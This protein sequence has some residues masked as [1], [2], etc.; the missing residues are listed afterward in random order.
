MQPI[1]PKLS[2]YITLYPCEVLCQ[3]FQLTVSCDLMH[4][5]YMLYVGLPR[6][7]QSIYYL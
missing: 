6:S 7:L 2:T 5:Y 3:I 4:V 1:V